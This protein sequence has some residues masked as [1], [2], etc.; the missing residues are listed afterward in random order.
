VGNALA[1]PGSTYSCSQHVEEN[2]AGRNEADRPVLKKISL[3]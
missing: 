1:L 2:I 3:E